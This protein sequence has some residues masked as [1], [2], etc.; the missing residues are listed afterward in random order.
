[1]YSKPII[2]D[3]FSTTHTSFIVNFDFKN[4]ITLV[5]GESGIG[6]SA[7]YSFI[8]ECCAMDSRIAC[9]NYLDF[10]KDMKAILEQTSGKLIVIDNGD[11]LLDDE[12]RKYIAFDQNNQYLIMGRNPKNLFA[13]KDNLY[14]LIS[15]PKGEQTEFRL[16]PYLR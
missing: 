6:K 14:E 11:I 8:A 9:F 3:N 1:M 2:M 12:T 10:N 7:S 13:T 16:K 15:I 4:N 5:M